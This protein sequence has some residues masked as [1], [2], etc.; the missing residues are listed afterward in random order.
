MALLTVILTVVV[1]V[2]SATLTAYFRFVILADIEEEH[3]KEMIHAAL[4]RWRQ[5]L[6]EE[7]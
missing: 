6:E 4:V 2:V 3:E 5:D 7:H 1:M